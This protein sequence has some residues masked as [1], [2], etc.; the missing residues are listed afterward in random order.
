MLFLRREQGRPGEVV[1]TIESFAAGYPQMPAWRCALAWT[2]AEL[3]SRPDARQE[4]DALARNDFRD[5]PRDWLWLISIAILGEVA[6]YLDDA[7]RA[8]LLYEPLLPYADRCV[9]VDAA[10]CLGSASRPLGLLATTVGSVDAAARHFQHALE[11]NA[12]IKSPLCVAHTQRDYAQTLLRRDHPGD[13]ENALTLLGATLATA[14]KLG[15]AALADRAQRLKHQAETTASRMSRATHDSSV[16][17]A[18]RAGDCL[19]G[20]A[21]KSGPN[22]HAGRGT[23]PRRTRVLGLWRRSAGDLS[24]SAC[25]LSARSV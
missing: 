3:D 11:F 14:D 20:R 19:S 15:L 16:T 5:L 25:G 18:T 10:F 8:K 24:R 2:F 7:R 1:E 13:R 22:G 21:S 23:S 17:L 9:V 12:R 4:L 6:A